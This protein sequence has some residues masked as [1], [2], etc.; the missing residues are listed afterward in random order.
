MQSGP[1]TEGAEALVAK[2]P[3]HSIFPGQGR[4]VSK[5]TGYLMAVTAPE[6]CF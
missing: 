5:D 3:G 6:N 1:Q 2:C 4:S